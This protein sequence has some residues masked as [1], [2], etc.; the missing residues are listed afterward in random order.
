MKDLPKFSL[1][2]VRKAE[3]IKTFLHKAFHSKKWAVSQLYIL[4]AN[5]FH[6]PF[7]CVPAYSGSNSI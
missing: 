7:I 4:Q 3:I 5:V 2:A 6:I 1:E